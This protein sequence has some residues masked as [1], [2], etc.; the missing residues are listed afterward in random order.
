MGQFGGKYGSSKGV[1]LDIPKWCQNGNRLA[2]WREM[3]LHMRATQCTKMFPFLLG[4]N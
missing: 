1:T 2:K 3:I 4:T